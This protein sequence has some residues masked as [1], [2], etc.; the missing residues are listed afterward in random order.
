M[1]EAQHF[2]IAHS[3]ATARGMKL[4]E[5]VVYL[6]GLLQSCS[7]ETDLRELQQLYVTLSESDKQLELIQNGQLKLS[8]PH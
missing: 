2:F 3:I 5:A 7:E 6:R 1:S 8:L 4:S